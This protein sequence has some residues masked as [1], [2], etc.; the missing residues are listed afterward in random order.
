M[1]CFQ[2]QTPNGGV[3]EKFQNALQAET[4]WTWNVATG[5]REKVHVFANNQA[6]IR[7]SYFKVDSNNVIWLLWR[8]INVNRQ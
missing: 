4:V 6:I 3:E 1:E 2:M 8:A 7:I 5:A